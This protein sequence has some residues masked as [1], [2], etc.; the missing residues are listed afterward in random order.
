MSK[1]A[2][3]VTTT[4]ARQKYSGAN[5]RLE[6]IDQF[7][8]NSGYEVLKC[9]Y[10]DLKEFCTLDKKYE[11][12]VIV[13]FV[14]IRAIKNLSKVSKLVWFDSIDSILHTRI[15]G[16]GRNQIISY[17]KGFL[18]TFIALKFGNKVNCV[19]YIS[20]NDKMWD[21]FLFKKAKK[22]VIPNRQNYPEIEDSNYPEEVFFVG[23]LNYNANRKALKKFLKIAHDIDS[24]LKTKFVVVTGSTKSKHLDMTLPFG[25]EVVFLHSVPI[26]RIYHAKSIHVVP[27]WNSVG[28]KNKVVEPASQGLPVI[29][30]S[31][32]FNGLNMLPNMVSV[33]DSTELKNN[34]LA[35]LR[36][37]KPIKLGLHEVVDKNETDSLN[38]WLR[39]LLNKFD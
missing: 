6:L 11:I 28:I 5:L 32:S 3:L 26:Q 22:F 8:Q 20:E 24:K 38:A 12:G 10:S 29:A 16:L 39:N 13:S 34:L 15:L 35:L 17:L 30:G 37:P 18:E 23:D 1:S 31:G 25:G 21:R 14:N 7:L 33:A 9:S 2:I 19:T 4:F 27:I 36:D